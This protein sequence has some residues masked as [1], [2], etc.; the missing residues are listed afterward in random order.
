MLGSTYSCR[1]RLHMVHTSDKVQGQIYIPVA[2]WTREHLLPSAQPMLNFVSS[3]DSD[4][5]CRRRLQ[6]RYSADQCLRLCGGNGHVHYNRAH[7]ASN[8]ICQT[9][10]LHSRNFVLTFLRIPGW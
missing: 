1:F 10:S 5:C 2:N 7:L 6:E 9:P 4:H 8:S 3:H